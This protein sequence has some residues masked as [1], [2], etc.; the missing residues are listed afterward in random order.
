[1]SG[2]TSECGSN[3]G[4]VEDAKVKNEDRALTL[5]ARYIMLLEEKIQRLERE[6]S[7][8]TDEPST[9]DK[10]L[11]EDESSES[12]DEGKGSKNED[13]DKENKNEDE[14]KDKDSVE[15]SKDKSRVRYVERKHTLLDYTDTYKKADEWGHGSGGDDGPSDAPIITW[16]RTQFSNSTTIRHLL[17]ESMALRNALREILDE[18]VEITFDTEEVAIRAPYT[19]LYHSEDKIRKF[20]DDPANKAVK[21]ELDILLEQI[22]KEQKAARKDI[23]AYKK[24]GTITYEYLWALFY[25]GCRV[26]TTVMEEPQ[27]LVVADQLPPP[28]FPGDDDDDTFQMYVVAIDWDGSEFQPVGRTVKFRKFPAT[29]SIQELEVCPLEYWKDPK[30]K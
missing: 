22:Q 17:I 7:N 20:A 25:P 5:E 19:I 3:A 10:I 27:M 13:E 4:I 30:G 1:M 8:A 29:K 24:N 2:M 28:L 12:E 6:A 23:A 9:S 26:I 18:S 15:S 14:N 16:R 21:P 11:K